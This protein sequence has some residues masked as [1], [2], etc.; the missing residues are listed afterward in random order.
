[1]TQEHLNHAMLHSIEK[2]ST[3]KLDPIE[4]VNMF[5][6]RNEERQRVFGVFYKEDLK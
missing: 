2:E 6:E 1:M 5:C 4:I 3:D